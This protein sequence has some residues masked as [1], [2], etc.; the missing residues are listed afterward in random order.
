MK[1]ACCFVFVFLGMIVVPAFAAEPVVCVSDV[2]GIVWEYVGALDDNGVNKGLESQFNPASENTG[3]FARSFGSSLM[4]A[5]SVWTSDGGIILAFQIVSD[6]PVNIDRKDMRIVTDDD[7]WDIE[8]M[9]RVRYKLIGSYI[10]PVIQ[11]LNPG[12]IQTLTPSATIH[13]RYLQ[14]MDMVSDS[15]RAVML[16]AYSESYCGFGD[17]SMTIPVFAV[18]SQSQAGKQWDNQKRLPFAVFHKSQKEVSLR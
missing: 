16:D 2:P 17:R 13:P 3:I 14:M 8:S 7:E 15:L 1:V 6:G 10:S 11:R 5:F 18:V 9:F 12:D 4:K